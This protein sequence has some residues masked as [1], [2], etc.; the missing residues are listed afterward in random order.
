MQ[1]QLQQHQ[2]LQQ[3]QPQDS[4]HTPNQNLAFLRYKGLGPFGPLATLGN[5]M[6]PTTM[7]PH[8]MGRPNGHLGQPECDYGHDIE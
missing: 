3:P 7:H 6:G 5:T 4:N 1:Q 2:Q 8:A